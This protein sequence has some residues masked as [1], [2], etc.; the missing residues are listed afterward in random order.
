MLSPSHDWTA[1]F[2]S[3]ELQQ[4]LA[5][6]LQGPI[7]GLEVTMLT[8]TGRAAAVRVTD[9]AG[10]REVPAA[11]IRALLGLRSTWFTLTTVPG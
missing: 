1:T 8:P 6:V 7:A 11:Q 4:R 9:A 5:T 2:T 10:A 3:A